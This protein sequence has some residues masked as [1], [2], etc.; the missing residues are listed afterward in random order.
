MCSKKIV[1][2]HLYDDVSCI[3]DVALLLI[4]LIIMMIDMIGGGGGGV[5][6]GYGVC[7]GGGVSNDDCVPV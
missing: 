4:V 7:N 3:I 2:N 1:V 6:E 5:Y